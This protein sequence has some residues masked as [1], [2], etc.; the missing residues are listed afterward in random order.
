MANASLGGIAISNQP[1]FS[2]PYL[3]AF[4]GSPEKTK[5][6]VKEIIERL[7]T[8]DAYPGDEDTGSMSAW[9]ILSTIKKFPLCPGSGKMLEI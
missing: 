6:V 1:S 7:F 2:L 9:Y 5:D 4:Y 8:P 3:F